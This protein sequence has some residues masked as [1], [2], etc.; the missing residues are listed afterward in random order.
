MNGR[1]IRLLCLG[2]AVVLALAAVGLIT[3]QALAFVTAV[4]INPDASFS[5]PGGAEV[6]VSGTLTCSPFSFNS[7]SVQVSQDQGQQQAF[8]FA[9][10]QVACSF[11]QP[12]GWIVTAP[13]SLGFHGG[14]ANVIVTVFNSGFNGA[15]LCRS[16][17]Q[18]TCTQSSNGVLGFEI[19]AVLPGA[20]STG[21]S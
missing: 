3:N 6:T 20:G 21:G 17:R 7:V 12:Q 8:A 11:N 16:L 2:V 4:T 10:F 9:S 5:Q 18:C 1:R 13:S 14:Q 19:C 15:I